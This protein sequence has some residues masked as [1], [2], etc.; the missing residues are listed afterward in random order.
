MLDAPIRALF[1]QVFVPQGCFTMGSNALGDLTGQIKGHSARLVCISQS[2]WI[3]KYE[4]TNAQSEQFRLESGLP[5]ANLGSFSS[6]TML[7]TPRVGMTLY[8]RNLR[9]NGGVGVFPPGAMGIRGARTE[10]AALPMGA[11]RKQSAKSMA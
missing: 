9:V 5:Q 3:D 11:I 6:S 4:V 2:Y 7:D 10:F 1:F 8:Q